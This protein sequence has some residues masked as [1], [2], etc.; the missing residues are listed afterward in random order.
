LCDYKSEV[1]RAVFSI[2][3]SHNC[4]GNVGRMIVAKVTLTTEQKELAA[5]Y[6][7]EKWP[8]ESVTFEAETDE[9]GDIIFRRVKTTVKTM[10]KDWKPKKYKKG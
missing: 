8:D 10:P 7:K 5:Q 2:I 3:G 4:A 1:W 6:A 9:Y